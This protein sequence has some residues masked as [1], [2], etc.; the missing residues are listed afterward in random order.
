[1]LQVAF[2]FI[3][4]NIVQKK[5]FSTQ[6]SWPF[7]KPVSKKMVKDY[8]DIIRHPMDLSI[9]AKKVKSKYVSPHVV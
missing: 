8:Y 4:D 5:L 2:D 6:D 3:L 1:M 7:M 9:I